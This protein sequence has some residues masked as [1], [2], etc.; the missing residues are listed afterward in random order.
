[1]FAIARF[2]TSFVVGY[3]AGGM[4]KLGASLSAS[5]FSRQPPTI[6]P[7]SMASS[8]YR[9]MWFRCAAMAVIAVITVYAAVQLGM[10]EKSLWE[11]SLALFA[12]GTAGALVGITFFVVFGSIGF[13]CGPVFGAVGVVGLALGGGVAGLGLTSVVNVLR[14]PSAYNFDLATIS[15]VLAMG[16]LAAYVVWTAMRHLE[17]RT[18]RGHK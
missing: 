11:R 1:M 5:S 10:H 9:L 17:T 13:V 12:G 3:S 2:R 18:S 4:T 15:A 14:N 8:S 6:E 16:A 7:Q